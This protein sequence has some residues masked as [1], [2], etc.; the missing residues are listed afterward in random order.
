MV[1]LAGVILGYWVF[2]FGNWTDSRNVVHLHRSFVKVKMMP[3]EADTTPWCAA[4][5]TDTTLDK[6]RQQPLSPR[7]I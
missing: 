1:N 7:Q 2:F 4:Y 6:E 5:S 3:F